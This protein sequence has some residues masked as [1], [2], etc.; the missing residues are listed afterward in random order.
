MQKRWNP[1]DRENVD[2]EVG[3]PV[4]EDLKPGLH[5]EKEKEET[6]RTITASSGAPGRTCRRGRWQSE[7]ARRRSRAEAKRWLK[8]K[9]G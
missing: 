7:S 8:T 5:Y 4:L 6:S 2:F 1:G 3:G 9:G